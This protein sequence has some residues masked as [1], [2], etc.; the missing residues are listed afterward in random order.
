MP[1]LTR[2][3]IQVLVQQIVQTRTAEIDCDE[4]MRVLVEYA[5]KLSSGEATDMSDELVRHHLEH[6][7]ECAEEFEMIRGIADEGSLSEE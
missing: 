7:V 2:E 4:M 3:Q 1:K 6:C 5:D